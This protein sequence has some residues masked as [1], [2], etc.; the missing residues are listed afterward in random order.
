MAWTRIVRSGKPR[1][2]GI[3]S[4]YSGLLDVEVDLKPTPSREWADFFSQPFAVPTKL[5]MH[6]PQL[7]GSTVLLMPPDGE[8]DAYVA[9]VDARIAAA[10]DFFEAQ[11][12]P[13]LQAAEAR[14]QEDKA[15]EQ[16]RVAE[17]R[18]KAEEL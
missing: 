6:P 11:V 14:A 7:S 17:A 8:L 18:R 4:Q 5:S 15:S 2:K 13:H 10:N 1:V 9:N 12:L 3:N 16:T